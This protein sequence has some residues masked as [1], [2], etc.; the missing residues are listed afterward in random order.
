MHDTDS[1]SAIVFASHSKNRQDVSSRCQLCHIAR[2]SR[3]H[4]EDLPFAPGLRRVW[5]STPNFETE[6]NVHPF[7]ACCARK[8]QKKL[9]ESL[10]GMNGTGV[11]QILRPMLPVSV[12]VIHA[13]KSY[14][15]RKV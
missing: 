12:T 7:A 15:T 8:Y 4:F 5:L 13:G 9:E 10:A 1:V 2:R 3:L 14:A 11:R 6:S